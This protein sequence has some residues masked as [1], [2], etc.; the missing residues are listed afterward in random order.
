[1]PENNKRYRIDN[2]HSKALEGNPLNSPA[3]RDLK[4]HLPP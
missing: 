3:D 4:I 1:M 2:F